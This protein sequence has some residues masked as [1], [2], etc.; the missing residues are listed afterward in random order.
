[1][2]ATAE[3]AA[4][5]TFDQQCP[6]E[7]THADLPL[8]C[9]NPRPASLLRNRPTAKT[10]RPFFR[11][12]RRRP[13]CG[14]GM[15]DGNTFG[16]PRRINTGLDPWS[17]ILLD[18]RSDAMFFGSRS[19]PTFFDLVAARDG[20]RLPGSPRDAALFPRAFPARVRQG[21]DGGQTKCPRLH[22]MSR[23]WFGWSRFP[24]HRVFRNAMLGPHAIGR[25]APPDFR[26]LPDI[27]ALDVVESHEVLTKL[28]VSQRC[29][30]GKA[31]RPVRRTRTSPGTGQ[32]CSSRHVRGGLK[33]R[34]R[35]AAYSV[36]SSRPANG[37]SDVGRTSFD[38]SKSDHSVTPHADGIPRID[39]RR[40]I[41]VSG[42]I[43]EVIV[44]KSRIHEQIVGQQTKIEGVTRSIGKPGLLPDGR[45][46]GNRGEQ[47]SSLIHRQIPMPLDK[48][49]TVGSPGIVGGSPDPALNGLAPITRL[50]G[51][52]AVRKGPIT[53]NPSDVGG[54]GEEA[55]TPSSW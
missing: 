2:I 15:E 9:S 34:S 33:S 10:L 45:R 5:A 39:S 28:L 3:R 13:S 12:C 35:T 55:S 7:N 43:P 1:M 23:S 42:V 53:G 54:R 14:S 6:A 50:P 27:A 16:T 36:A 40:L 52:I 38:T 51:V 25:Q 21:A 44:L 48:H 20:F 24:P 22:G 26:V 30:T 46:K 29:A 19:N 32:P 11:T 31:N 47:H 17:P 49:V 37:D 4:D 41:L 18:S 8:S